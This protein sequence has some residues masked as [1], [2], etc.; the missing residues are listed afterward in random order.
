MLYAT[1]G[2]Y[3]NDYSTQPL[4]IKKLIIDKPIDQAFV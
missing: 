3:C 4:E 1:A 2:L